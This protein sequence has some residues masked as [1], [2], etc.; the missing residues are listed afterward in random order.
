MLSKNGKYW[1]KGLIKFEFSL[2]PIDGKSEVLQK[3]CL[4]VVIDVVA[5]SV[6][7]VVV[8][9]V[10]IVDVDFELDRLLRV[11]LPDSVIAGGN[12]FVKFHLQATETSKT[13]EEL[14]R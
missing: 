7:S 2:S 1:S 4:V 11:K 10:V 13:F 3:F 8:V 9:V 5:E 12:F 14:D 6:L